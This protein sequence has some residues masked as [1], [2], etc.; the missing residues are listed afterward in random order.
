MLTDPALLSS[1]KSLWDKL[2]SGG[3]NNPLDAIEQ[4]SFLL[5]LK[6]LDEQEEDAQRQARLRK[7]DYTPFFPDENLRWSYWSKL[8]A[9]QALDIVKEK[10]F[11]YIK[12]LGD[13]GGDVRDPFAVLMANAEF[14][15]NKPPCSSRPARPSTPCRSPPRTRTCRETFMSISSAS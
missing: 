9:R 1:I 15:I 8:E 12:K 5:F 13:S 11:P 7:Q 3:L 10:V 14:K 2:W 6:R 4:L